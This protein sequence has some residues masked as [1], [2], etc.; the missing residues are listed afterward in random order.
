VTTLTFQLNPSPTAAKFSVERVSSTCITPQPTGNLRGIEMRGNAARG[1]DLRGSETRPNVLE[2][3]K[4][5]GFYTS[6][7]DGICLIR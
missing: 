3:Y 5:L 2:G 4:M 1:N 7:A 6:N